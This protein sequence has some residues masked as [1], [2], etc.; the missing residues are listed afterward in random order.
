V[1]NGRY[2]RTSPT[3]RRTRRSKDRVPK[4]SRSRNA[5]VARG[6]PDGARSLRR[7]KA[8]APAAADEK[9]A[10]YRSRGREKDQEENEGARKSTG[11]RKNASP[12]VDATQRRQERRL[13]RRR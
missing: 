5:S 12:P 2:G 6:A 9:S 13:C 11:A 8:A 4:S 1:L 7:G 3:R 10:H